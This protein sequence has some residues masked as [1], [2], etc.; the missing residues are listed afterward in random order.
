MQSYPR[1]MPFQTGLGERL[2]WQRTGAELWRLETFH[3]QGRL[4]SEGRDLC[5]GQAGQGLDFRV[6]GC[7]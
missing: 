2:S 4:H 5:W 1:V 7:M 6:L 3:G